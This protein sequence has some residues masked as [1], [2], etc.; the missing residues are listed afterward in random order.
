MNKKTLKHLR[1]A[2][3]NNP[4]CYVLITCSQPSESGQME[5]EMSYQGD[6]CLASYLLQEA[7]TFI[8]KE[9]QIEII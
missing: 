8:E 3:D 2:L 4:S 7:Q 9:E 1:G 5:V 6:L